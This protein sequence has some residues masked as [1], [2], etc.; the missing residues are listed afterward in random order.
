MNQNN[1]QSKTSV[2]PPSPTP[3]KLVTLYSAS[4]WEEFIGEW[5]EGFQPAYEQVSRIGGA[6]DMGRDVIG[7]LEPAHVRPRPCDIYQCKHYDHP[8]TPTDIYLELGK[9]CVHTYR[10]DYPVPRRYRF[11]PPRGIGPK[12]PWCRSAPR[13]WPRSTDDRLAL[14]RERS[15]FQ[16]RKQAS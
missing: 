11:V 8:L 9:L 13:V 2:G 4:E 10:L 14:K 6:G 12:P 16:P 1:K 5:A 15:Y 7:H 3:A